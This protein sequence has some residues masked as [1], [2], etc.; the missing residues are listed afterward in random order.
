MWLFILALQPFQ[1]PRLLPSLPWPSPFLWES[2][3]SCFAMSSELIPQLMGPVR[4]EAEDRLA[5]GKVEER[6]GPVPP[7]LRQSH[8]LPE[9]RGER[10]RYLLSLWGRAGMENRAGTCRL[11]QQRKWP[12]V[13]SAAHESLSSTSDQCI[14]GLYFPCSS[15]LKWIVILL[16]IR[17]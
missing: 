1:K 7:L 8:H 12:K 3:L 16:L 6:A 5:P 17:V 15:C 11:T 4:E 14:T 10:L 2:L 13:S 9:R